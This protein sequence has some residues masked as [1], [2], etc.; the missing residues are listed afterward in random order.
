MGRN[1]GW[2]LNVFDLM[3]LN[4]GAQIECPFERACEL[5]CSRPFFAFLCSSKSAGAYAPS[6]LG[7]FLHSAGNFFW[8]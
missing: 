8:L 6:A 5:R 3:V 1:F 4:T 7:R 2:V